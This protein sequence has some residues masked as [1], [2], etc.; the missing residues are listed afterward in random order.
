MVTNSDIV[1][2]LALTRIR[3]LTPH[4]LWRVTVCSN[5][6]VVKI[7][8]LGGG[9]RYFVCR[10]DRKE[11]LRPFTRSSTKKCVPLLLC[12]GCRSSTY[13]LRRII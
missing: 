3:P 11:G 6:S 5:V 4:I 10:L 7:R 12:C 1:L 8:T 2:Y 13:I 9:L